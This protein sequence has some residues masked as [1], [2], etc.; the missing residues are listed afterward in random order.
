MNPAR[1]SFSFENLKI[2]VKINLLL[3][4]YL[5]LRLSMLGPYITIVHITLFMIGVLLKSLVYPTMQV[6]T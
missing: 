2:P 4:P 1:H 5:G 6:Y 3:K